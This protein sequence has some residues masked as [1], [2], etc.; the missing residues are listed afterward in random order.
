MHN[1]KLKREGHL[2]VQVTQNLR[3]LGFAITERRKRWND[4]GGCAEGAFWREGL[5]HV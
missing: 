4:E 2:S 3:I 5:L 1:L